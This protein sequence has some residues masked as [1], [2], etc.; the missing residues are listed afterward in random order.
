MWER[1]LVPRPSLSRDRHR[2]LAGQ[3]P[4]ADGVRAQLPEFEKINESTTERRFRK[5]RQGLGKLTR[6]HHASQNRIRTAGFSESLALFSVHKRRVLNCQ[7]RLLVRGAGTRTFETAFWLQRHDRGTI[8][9]SRVSDCSFS[10]H[11]RNRLLMIRSTPRIW[12]YGTP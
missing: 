4:T 10:D 5:L 9:K 6:S 7:F 8:F 12:A 11:R 2:A 3:K 1:L